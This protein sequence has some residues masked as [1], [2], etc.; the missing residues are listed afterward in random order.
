MQELELLHRK[1]YSFLSSKTESN[2]VIFSEYL[3]HN[4]HKNTNHYESNSAHSQ[5]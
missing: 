1:F 4:E 5:Y 3:F 2:N